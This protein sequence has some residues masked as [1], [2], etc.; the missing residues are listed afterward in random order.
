M[1]VVKVGIVGSKSIYK[2]DV[3]SEEENFHHVDDSS[4]GEVTMDV[5]ES[6]GKKESI[7]EEH[8]IF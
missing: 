2:D 6:I 5:D 7:G 4:D 1:F 8:M 3:A